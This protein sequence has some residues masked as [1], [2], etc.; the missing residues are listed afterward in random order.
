MIYS[1][2][3]LYLGVDVEEEVLL[4][5]NGQELTCFANILPCGVQKESVYQVELIPMVFNDY[6]VTESHDGVFP[7]IVRVGNTFSYIVTGMLVGNRLDSGCIVFEDDVLLS[8]F[9]HLEGKIISWKVDR[10]DAD[11]H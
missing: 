4:I 11:F 10:I 1:A 7:S 6:V 9:G 2:Q 3:V 5:I 8:N